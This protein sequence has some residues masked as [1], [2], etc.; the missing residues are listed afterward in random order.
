LG[1]KTIN[2]VE[3]EGS[4]ITNV[5]PPNSV[6]NDAPITITTERWTSPQLQIV[7]SN[8]RTDPRQGDLTMRLDNLTT[9]EPDPGLFLVPDGYQIVDETGPS[10]KIQV[11]RQ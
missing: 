2:G 7:V 3:V 9:A 6:G 1:T 5:L 4:R 10:F 11:A 8:T